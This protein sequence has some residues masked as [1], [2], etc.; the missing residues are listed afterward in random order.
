MGLCDTSGLGKPSQSFLQASN[1]Y[2]V[3][4]TTFIHVTRGACWWPLLKESVSPRWAYSV[5]SGEMVVLGKREI[6]SE[7]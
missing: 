7:T 2:Y 5:Y 3:A 1:F 4:E 6:G